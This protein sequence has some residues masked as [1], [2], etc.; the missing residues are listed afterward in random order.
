MKARIII[1]TAIIGVT[2][3]AGVVNAAEEGNEDEQKIARTDM[4]AAVQKTIQD[5]FAG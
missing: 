2:P 1:A 5:I 3:L 4:P